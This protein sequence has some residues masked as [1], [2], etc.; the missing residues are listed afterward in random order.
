MVQGLENPAL[1][2]ER[3]TRETV[4]SEVPPEELD[5]N[6]SILPHIPSTS[7]FSHASAARF[8][9]GV[10]GVPAV[11]DLDLGSVQ[12]CPLTLVILRSRARTSRLNSN[13]LHAQEDRSAE[14]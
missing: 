8:D 4:R 11:N 6:V 3:L 2:R 12:G 10:Y 9:R 1:S 13:H 5:G 7:N 14:H